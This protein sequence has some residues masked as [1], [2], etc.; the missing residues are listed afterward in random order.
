LPVVP[1]TAA[2]PGVGAGAV[3][4][5]RWV[6]PLVLGVLA[7]TALASEQ[8]QSL[9]GPHV[10]IRYWPNQEDAAY[11]VRRYAAEALPLLAQVLGL[12]NDQTV[13]IE[14]ARSQEEFNRLVG[15]RMPDWTLG[16]AFHHQLRVVL[17]P[18]RGPD[19]RRLVIHELTHVMLD[20]KL[21]K[22]GAEAPRWVHEGLAQWMEG[23]M[24][25]AQKDVLGQAAVEGRLLRLSELNAAFEG[26]RERVDLAYAQSVTLIQYMQEHG[27]PGALGK[28]LEYL[29]QTGDETLALRWAMAQDPAVVEKRWLEATRAQYL[30]RGVPLSVDLA[31]FALMA[32]LFVVA[33][34]VRM[35]IAREIRERMQE[36]ERLRQLFQGV[37][38]P[39]EYL[40]DTNDE[41]NLRD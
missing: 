40:P 21:G 37:D 38:A 19:L 11:E 34:V 18:L 31:I 16:V 27:P 6:G 4:G 20:R 10:E 25:P 9:G 32:L 7:S 17:K 35:R 24:T 2:V 15:Q 33:V 41:W 23:D 14:I 29:A 39:D 12:P 5:W 13:T 36:E 30:A 1:V 8:R 3:K 26:K 22:A 28:F